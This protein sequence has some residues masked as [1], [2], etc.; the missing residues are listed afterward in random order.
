MAGQLTQGWTQL[1]WN[2][3]ERL[4]AEP[5]PDVTRPPVSAPSRLPRQ[6]VRLKPDQ[7]RDLVASYQSG[8]SV[9]EVAQKFSVTPETASAKLRAAGITIRH[10]KPTIPESELDTLRTLYEQGATL[11]D[12]GKRYGCSRTTVANA[13]QAHGVA[14]R[15]QPPS[16]T[17]EQIDEAVRRYESGDSLAKVA[18]A[19]G[20]STRTIYVRLLERGVLMRDKQGRPR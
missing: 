7:V 16:L 10:Q 20:V 12:L 19:L 8:M 4:L 11:V 13:L 17:L 1:V 2:S 15:G 3:V 18:T 5:T 6:L 14:L 9:T